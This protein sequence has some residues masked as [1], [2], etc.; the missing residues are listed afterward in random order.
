MPGSGQELHIELSGKHYELRILIFQVR[1]KQAQRGQITCKYAT[2]GT[3][4]KHL[5]TILR[6]GAPLLCS[7]NTAFSTYNTQRSS[8]RFGF[9]LEAIPGKDPED[10]QHCVKV[11]G[12]C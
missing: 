10:R 11:Q 9:T 1:R 3:L 5:A 12:V 7:L 6:G 2:P 4:W 8:V